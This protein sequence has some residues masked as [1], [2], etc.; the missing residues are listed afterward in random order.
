MLY[1]IRINTLYLFIKN[2]PLWSTIDK[3]SVKECSPPTMV[4]CT[5][6]YVM[7]ILFNFNVFLLNVLPTGTTETSEIF[8]F[9]NKNNRKEQCKGKAYEM[10]SRKY[11]SL[12]RRK[13]AAEYAMKAQGIGWNFSII[14]KI[15]KE[16]NMTS[17]LY[18]LKRLSRLLHIA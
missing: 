10:I 6:T 13:L 4:K 15:I 12:G 5:P 1:N 11:R 3:G 8:E 2:L 16:N 18:A 14:D 17:I 9:F 7:P